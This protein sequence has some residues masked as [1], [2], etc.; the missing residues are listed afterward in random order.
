MVKWRHVYNMVVACWNS[1]VESL[2]VHFYVYQQ[3]KQL[4]PALYSLIGKMSV[5][6][7]AEPLCM[8]EC[9]C[10]CV[11]QCER[12]N[13]CVCVSVCVCCSKV[14][15]LTCD[16][17]CVWKAPLFATNNKQQ[18]HG[19]TAMIC[20]DNDDD[21]QDNDIILLLPAPPSLLCLLRLVLHLVSFVSFRIKQQLIWSRAGSS[22]A[23]DPHHLATFLCTACSMYELHFDLC[24]GV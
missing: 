7:L 2:D 1:I 17:L 5:F 13:V 3:W 21:D 4:F 15:P 23:F 18:Q 12:A 10:V 19:A 24:V 14:C 16:C 8:C 20:S 6:M 9:E 11:S 22:V